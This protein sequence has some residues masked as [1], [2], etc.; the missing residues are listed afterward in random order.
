MPVHAPSLSQ[1]GF[2]LI[3]VL[4]ALLILSFGMLGLI[5]MQ[6]FALKSNHEA[7]L[8]TEGTNL[9]RELAEMMRG[10]NLIAIKTK[11]LD[12]PYLTDTLDIGTI[13]TT[14]L[15]V[16]NAC[17]TT[18]EVASAQMAEWR[19]RVRNAL[20]GARL[21]ICFDSEPY[22]HSGLPQWDCTP[23][24]AGGSEVIV[25]KLGWNLRS[26]NSG[27][28]DEEAIIRA[29][30]NNSRPQIILPVTGGNPFPL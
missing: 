24:A 17:A 22:D 5:G 23:G 2:T 15:A 27:A 9:A 11:A 14:C 8:Y 29:N 30:D 19:T 4:I 7:K 26:T 10:N 12:N 6:A 1:K 13:T 18:Q 25:L 28:T 21:E 3:E 20:P 16:G